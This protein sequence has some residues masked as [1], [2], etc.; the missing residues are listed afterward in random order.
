MQGTILDKI[1]G[2]IP[3]PRRL[4]PEQIQTRIK[5][6]LKQKR[7]V[8]TAIERQMYVPMEG[9]YG[10]PFVEHK[11]EKNY[12]IIETWDKFQPERPKDR[13]MKMPKPRNFQHYVPLKDDALEEWLGRLRGRYQRFSTQVTFERE[14]DWLFAKLSFGGNEKRRA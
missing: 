11:E 3:K 8:S 1:P 13:R 2:P 5:T 7:I 14:S 10:L 12:K 4:K 6:R 9:Q